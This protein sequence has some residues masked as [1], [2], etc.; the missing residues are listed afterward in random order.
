MWFRLV[1]LPVNPT[2]LNSGRGHHPRLYR[3][4]LVPG[5]DYK[6]N[7]AD[8]KPNSPAVLY[9]IYSLRYKSHEFLFFH[10]QYLQINSLLRYV[11]NER[12][13]GV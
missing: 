12:D 1:N 8:H 5:P 4:R 2:H 11:Q 10:V 7:V 6:R 13:G 9:S 3:I